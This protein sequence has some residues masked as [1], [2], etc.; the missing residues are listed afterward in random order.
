MGLGEN[1]NHTSG[2]LCRRFDGVV[3]FSLFTSWINIFTILYPKSYE[4]N[5]KSQNGNHIIKIPIQGYTNKTLK[6]MEFQK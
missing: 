5:K 6:Q 3:L 2:C 4:K 1:I